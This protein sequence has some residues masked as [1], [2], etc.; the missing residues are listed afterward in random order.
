M[1]SEVL[2]VK[3]K[4]GYGMGDVVSY[5]I[6]DNVMLYMMFFYIDIFGIFVGFVGIMFLVVRV[7][8]AIFDFCMGLLV[9]RTRFRWGKFRSWV[10]FGVLLFGIVCVLVYSTLDF[11]MNGKMIYVVIIYILFIL[12]Y[13]VVNIF[14][15]VLGGVIINDSI[16]RISL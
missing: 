11:S 2:F 15:C 5:I 14:Y 9:D 12:F 13:I 10:L 7:L 1:K 3:E 16:Q 8:D 4:I 6:F